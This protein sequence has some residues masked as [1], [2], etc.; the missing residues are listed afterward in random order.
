MCTCVHVK[1]EGRDCVHVWVHGGVH[2][3]V[4]GGDCTCGGG[5]WDDGVCII[6]STCGELRKRTRTDQIGNH[7]I[8]SCQQL[9]KGSG[10][11]LL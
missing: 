3:R 1:V 5:G 10:G 9:C 11:P 7:D 8:C 4:D 6:R 2:V